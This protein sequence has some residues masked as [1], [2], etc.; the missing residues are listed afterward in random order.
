M[1]I[2]PPK[3]ETK[4]INLLIIFLQPGGQRLRE[5]HQAKDL[6]SSTMA[7]QL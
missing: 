3:N 1:A 5:P 2:L 4:S 7:V 6:L